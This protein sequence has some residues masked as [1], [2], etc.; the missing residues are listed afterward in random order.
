MPLASSGDPGPPGLS[1]LLRRAVQKQ[2]SRPLLLNLDHAVH[3]NS[4][5]REAAYYGCDRLKQR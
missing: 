3:P 1:R 2:H 4:L 5:T